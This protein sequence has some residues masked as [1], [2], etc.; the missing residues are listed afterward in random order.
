M[1]HELA[2]RRTIEGF[3]DLQRTSR[4]QV[5]V[6]DGLACNKTRSATVR[7]TWCG[8][9]GGCLKGQ[10]LLSSRTD[11]RRWPNS[12]VLLLD[13]CKLLNSRGVSCGR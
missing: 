8:Q 6:R 5:E 9:S 10:K 1:D 7:L 2:G 11:A 13:H 4:H 3:G 12:E